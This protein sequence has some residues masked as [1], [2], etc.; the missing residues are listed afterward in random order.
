MSRG[1]LGFKH[2]EKRISHFYLVNNPSY[3]PIQMI[4]HLQS[5]LPSP[6]QHSVIPHPSEDWN[7]FDVLLKKE[8]EEQ[9]VQDEKRTKKKS[10]QNNLN[11]FYMITISY[12]T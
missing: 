5:L 1:F 4:N 10:K 7:P 3:K 11:L 9:N 6:L 12:K 8:G 2:G